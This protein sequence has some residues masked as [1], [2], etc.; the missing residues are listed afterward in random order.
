[1]AGSH[2]P[3]RVW[4]TGAGKGIGRS[5]AWEYAKRGWSVAASARTEESEQPAATES[6][7]A[8]GSA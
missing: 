8:V 7:A 6:G 5:V 4:I 1:M 2:I 3:G